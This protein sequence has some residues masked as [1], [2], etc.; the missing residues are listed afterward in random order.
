MRTSVLMILALGLSPHLA[1]QELTQKEAVQA[2]LA[3]NPRL[4]AAQ[5]AR[6]SATAQA[7]QATW[8][9]LG[10]LDLGLQWNPSTQGRELSLPT[11]PPLTLQMGPPFRNQAEVSFTQPLWTWG[12]LSGRTAAARRR[13]ESSRQLETREA[14]VVAFEATRAYLEALQA[15]E[16]VAVAE[17]TVAQGQSFLLTA[18]AR[19]AQGASPRLDVLKADLSL[20][21][22]DS[23]LIAA[24]NQDRSAR[25]ALVT[26][27]KD[28]RFRSAAL[29]PFEEPRQDLPAEAEALAQARSRR[30]D[31]KGS[32]AQAEALRIGAAAEQ[33][34]GLPSLHFRTAL[35]VASDH[36]DGLGQ[37]SNR[38]YAVGLALQWEA[39]SSKRAQLR[40]A[41]FSARA[42]AQEA[43]TRSLEDQ[44]TQDV[45][46]QRWRIENARAQV[47]VA[48]RALLQAEEQARVSRLAYQEGI[49]TAVERQGDE[50]AL[51]DARYRLIAARLDLGLAWA[52]LRLALGE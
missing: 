21:E 45:R 52:S 9:Q 49:R 42:R 29:H 20:S 40:K 39:L 10:R 27:T 51:S 43:H 23:R 44:L 15:Q 17:Q 46:N 16:A 18:R 38:T 32:A 5:A 14:Q 47:D 13:E 48:Q 50:V 31:L 3:S 41:D 33:A 28:E 26:V 19:V 7:Q 24:R 11:A 22:A 30:P 8:D 35:T 34:A 37:T 25:E 12:A 1:G 36:T 2:A 6:E 4:A